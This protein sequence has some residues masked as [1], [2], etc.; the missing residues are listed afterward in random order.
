[1]SLEHFSQSF[2]T[3]DVSTKDKCPLVDKFLREENKLFATRYLP[4]IVQLQRRVRDK[5][6]HRLDRRE[7]V[8]TT[9]KEFL[10]R[11]RNG[12]YNYLYTSKIQFYNINLNIFLV[13]I[14]NRQEWEDLSNLVNKFATAWCMIGEDV[15][16]NGRLK[17]E[18]ALDQQEITPATCLAYLLPSSTREGVLITSLTDYLVLIHN[19]FVHACRDR[20]KEYVSYRIRSMLY[21]DVCVIQCIVL[22][23]VVIR[24]HSVS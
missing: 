21:T 14:E 6:L 11:I 22:G 13:C 2:S 16:K 17:I 5:F 15:R 9:I 3:A 24:Y 1:M 7:A 18:E 20:V 10:D 23:P 12:E 19:S 4:D 8:N